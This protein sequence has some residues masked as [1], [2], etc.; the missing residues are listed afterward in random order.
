[1][2][3]RILTTSR[4]AFLLACAALIGMALLMIMAEDGAAAISVMAGFPIGAASEGSI[5]IAAGLDLV[6]PLGYGAGFILLAVGLAK[7]ET[8][9]LL[10]TALILMTIVGMS[11]DFLENGTLLNL[12]NPGEE[13]VF[14]T[15]AKFG[16]LGSM[17]FMLTLLFTQGGLLTGLALFVF[18]YIT[19]ILLAA[20]IMELTG[21]AGVWLFI[22][23]LLFLF[24]FAA[25]IAHSEAQSTS[26]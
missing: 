24:G 19:P 1:M 6:I 5:K 22:P 21:D 23:S 26:E 13:G 10:V 8:S 18:R 16:I 14:V 20:N 3:S 15:L 12:S 7:D 2:R 4:D 9:R 11:L 25:V 17:G